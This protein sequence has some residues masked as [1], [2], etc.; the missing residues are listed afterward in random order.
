MTSVIRSSG[1]GDLLPINPMIDQSSERTLQV[2][3]TQGKKSIEE[4]LEEKLANLEK[5]QNL[6]RLLVQVM[7]VSSFTSQMGKN[8]A[9]NQ[10]LKMIPDLLERGKISAATYNCKW[11]YALTAI[12]AAITVGASGFAGYRYCTDVT[13][14]LLKTMNPQALATSVS[15]I[16]SVQAGGSALGQAVGTGGQLRSQNLTGKRE[17]YTSV[18]Q[19]LT[20]QRDK[21]RERESSDAKKVSEHL[22][23]CLRVI[24]AH[25][26]V[27]MQASGGQ[28]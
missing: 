17:V 28:G 25:H 8:L 2:Q 14:H 16:G 21:L 10:Y 26:R 4:K 3:S 5:N 12:G 24:E 27:C 15:W 9:V 7:T 11:V 23:M 1:D 13:D 6:M 22:D 18:I 20:I 19:L